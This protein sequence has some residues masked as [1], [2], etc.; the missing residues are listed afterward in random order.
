[1]HYKIESVSKK[2]DFAFKDAENK[3]VFKLVYDNWFTS[4]GRAIINKQ[5]YS[6]ESKN[7]WQHEFIFKK[8][9]EKIGSMSFNFKGNAILNIEGEY[10]ILKFKGLLNR[11]F[12]L[13]DGKD[14]VLMVLK[15]NIKWSKL[16][17]EYDV[18]T[19]DSLG[20]KEELINL[21]LFA[22]YAANISTNYYWQA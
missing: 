4:T 15:P 10:Y 22:S 14:N 18:E 7:I 17:Y 21:F 2:G 1:M 16:R 8:G 19:S 20:E 9:E 12:E 3:E 6:I 13:L 5:S 11:R